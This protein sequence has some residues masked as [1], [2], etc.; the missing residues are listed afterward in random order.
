MDSNYFDT[1]YSPHPDRSGVWKAICEYLQ[2]FVAP[3]DAVMDV[4]AG[5]CDFI[6]QIQASNKYAVDVNREVARWCAPDVRFV[7]AAPVECIDLPPHSIDVAFMS[8]FLEHLSPQ[9]CSRLF[10][11][12]DN[13]LTPAGKIL[14][15]QPNYFYCYRR[16]WDDFTHIRAFSHVSLSDFVSSRGYEI[17]SL[18]KGF[19]PFSFKSYHPKSYWITK[20]YLASFWRPQAAQ[21]LLV[22]QRY[23]PAT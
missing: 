13:L 19:L 2:K 1:R 11:R 9:E 14:I 23:V 16:Y 3:S 4:G 15:I 18:E 12:F 22:A 20:L 6:N 21:M 5:Y 8:N 10:D 7:H 17:V